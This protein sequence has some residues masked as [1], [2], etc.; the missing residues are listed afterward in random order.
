M[1]RFIVIKPMLLLLVFAWLWNACNEQKVKPHADISGLQQQDDRPSEE[2]AGVP[3]YS[4]SQIHCRIDEGRSIASNLQVGCLI[5]D[6]EGNRVDLPDGSWANF[7]V[8][9]EAASTNLLIKK[10]IPED[11]RQWDV[12][13]SFSGLAEQELR[14]EISQSTFI[15]EYGN[16]TTGIQT[17]ETGGQE[18]PSFDEPTSEPDDVCSVGSEKNGV[19]YFKTTSSCESQ[20]AG[21][22]LTPDQAVISAIGSAVESNAE[23]CFQ[24]YMSIDQNPELELEKI[25]TPFGVGCHQF[26]NKVLW[27]ANDT[28]L[29]IPPP[30]GANRICACQGL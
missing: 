9:P 16:A 8:R 2:S 6:A 12:L 24:I 14:L 5:A 4:N 29:S 1:H 22:G 17:L 11:S 3:G 10:L 20:C 18:T 13:F 26:K 23:A 7:E 15:F 27:D 25:K 28:S 30:V 21:F 19:C